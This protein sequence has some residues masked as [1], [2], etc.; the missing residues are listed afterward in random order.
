MHYQTLPDVRVEVVRTLEHR[1]FTWD[2]LVA[3]SRHPTPFASSWWLETTDPTARCLLLVLS[4][5]DLIGGLA[6]TR[7]QWANITIFGL[8]GD[9]AA[10]DHLDVLSRPEDETL[11]TDVLRHWFRGRRPYL[12]LAEGVDADS[13]LRRIFRDQS[14]AIQFTTAPYLPIRATIRPEPVS[15]RLRSTIRRGAKRLARAGL[16]YR[17][18]EGKS[19][20]FKRAVD[21]L[22]RLHMARW[23]RGSRFLRA[24]P[25]LLP[26]LDA[27]AQAGK[28]EIHELAAGENV[29]ASMLVF[30]E[31]TR[32]CFYQSGR[33]LE[34][35][36]RAAGSVLMQFVIED[37]QTRGACEFDFLR[38]AESYKSD[39]TEHHRP[40]YRLFAAEGAVARLALS[41]LVTAERSKPLVRR[42][43][44][45][46]KLKPGRRPDESSTLTRHA[47]AASPH[48]AA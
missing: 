41:V 8:P 29:V 7:R 17:R 46:S 44:T 38:G 22:V 9:F 48:I 19:L 34:H 21:I 37:S 12:M 11:V 6:L 14:T 20:N 32:C 45:Q 28:V 13:L 43:R 3:V 23:P 24:L 27:G 33:D 25:R 35:E 30:V 36:W 10:P 1:R 42:L 18:V 15:P 2:R 16:R 40:L 5:D 31:G 39:W 26:A 47:A 4:G